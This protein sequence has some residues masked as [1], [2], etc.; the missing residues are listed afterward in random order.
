[1]SIDAL[2]QA[3]SDGEAALFL[4]ES[5]VLDGGGPSTD[6][7][8]AWMREL[9]PE[10]KGKDLYED[11]DEAI[12]F[13][14][15]DEWKLRQGLS[16]RYQQAVPG[17]VHEVLPRFSWRAI[18]A[19]T[20]DALIERAYEQPGGQRAQTPVPV[21]GEYSFSISPGRRS[22]PLFRL[23]G[24]CS[25]VEP[26]ARAVL[27][28]KE[29]DSQKLR[30]RR[31]CSAIPDLV[32]DGI[33]V[34]AG[35]D[36]GEESLLEVLRVIEESISRERVPTTY[37][38]IG[39]PSPRL[40]R[41]AETLGVEIIS[42]SF[43]E[44]VARLAR[45]KPRPSGA[46]EEEI[47]A[48]L[49]LSGQRR[50]RISE[51]ELARYERQFELL[52]HPGFTEEEAEVGVTDFLSRSVSS[53]KP[54]RRG[55]DF[56]RQAIE[57]KTHTD[58]MTWTER[59]LE[60]RR[61]PMVVAARV[62]GPTAVGK[63]VLAKRLCYDMY[64]RGYPV[65]FAAN[66]PPDLDFRLIEDV[67]TKVQPET[68]P[69]DGA[70]EESTPS[71]PAIQRQ[72]PVLVVVDQAEQSLPLLRSLYRFFESRS[73]RLVLVAFTRTGI[74]EGLEGEDADWEAV[75]LRLV[76]AD[77]DLGAQLDPDEAKALAEHFQQLANVA[78]V[79]S[80][81]LL[82]N[83]FWLA[84]LLETAQNSDVLVNIARISPPS[85]QPISESLA[86]A[87]DGWPEPAQRLFSAIASAHRFHLKTPLS[88]AFR[89]SCPWAR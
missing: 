15:V 40:E 23:T 18:F 60:S 4:G 89:C 37:A 85:I 30:W 81:T 86:S 59:A 24:S 36:E 33:L 22:V 80:E 42:E 58:L 35:W 87:Y 67:W 1:M 82:Q 72:V 39:A 12:R 54:F 78:N 11:A 38:I 9:Y 56:R 63:T 21:L 77:F 73:R 7:L 44:F 74:W 76:H 88:L 48:E 5:P 17:L 65:I 83:S 52:H 61:G 2:F 32:W 25:A 79:S 14:G 41:V 6:S 55:W 20:P 13:G 10:A 75:P 29:R 62:Q 84:A 43:Q 28:T 50:I 68:P 8:R 57:T 16:A 64:S 49:R 53:W 45:A 34:F 69:P 51:A 70:Q 71:E 66:P 27:T 26:N 3:I 46:V 19:Y 47:E 31:W